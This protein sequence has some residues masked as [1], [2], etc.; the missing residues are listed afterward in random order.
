MRKQFVLLIIL[1]FFSLSWSQSI[2]T[3]EAGEPDTLE[4]EEDI[5]AMCSLECA[6]GWGVE[7]TSFLTDKK[8]DFKVS[9]LNDGRTSTAW[10][11]GNKRNG[12]GETITFSFSKKDMQGFDSLRFNGF[13]LL[14]GFVKDIAVWQK[15]GRI[16]KGIIMYNR[17]TIGNVVFYDSRGIQEVNIDEFYIKPD[18]KV[19][20]RIL[21]IYPGSKYKSVA[22]SEL[23]PLG[24]H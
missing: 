15:Y 22:I 8:N 14:N 3:F 7:A 4:K 16:K 24:A 9:N 2:P 6:I 23:I 19:S 20:F 10:V 17:R 21:E 13:R 18:S 12:I 1:F 5:G 11:S